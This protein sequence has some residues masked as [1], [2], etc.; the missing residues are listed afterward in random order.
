M[1][2]KLVAEIGWSHMGNMSLAQEMICAAAESGADYA[3][4]QTWKESRLKPGPWDQD[5]RREIYKEAEL[6]PNDYLILKECC[7]KHHIQFLTSCFCAEDL[8][9]IRNITNE[10]KIPSTECFND[11][12][13]GNAISL[14]DNVYL[15]TGA[16]KEIEYSKWAHFD[17]VYLL[18]CVSCYPC[19]AGLVNLQRIKHLLTLTPRV[20]YSGHYQGI[21]DAIA[22]MSMG[23]QVVEKHFTIDRKLSGRDNKFALLPVEFSDINVFRNELPK[24]NIDHGINYQECE[25]EAREV[26][27]RRWE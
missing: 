11:N 10:I 23:V 12:L 14:F 24:M 15:S 16:S 27:A 9:F 25:T 4:F 5:G 19:E 13:V 18:H 7:D 17:N 21:W 22:A 2:C 20:G 3:K 8:L 1:R 6:F 26:Y